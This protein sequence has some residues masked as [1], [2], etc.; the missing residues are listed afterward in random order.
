MPFPRPRE[1]KEEGHQRQ[2]GT[3]GNS[4]EQPSP[5]PGD[6]GRGGLTGV[7]GPI[8]VARRLKKGFQ[9]NPQLGIVLAT[10]RGHGV[11]YVGE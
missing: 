2:A 3:N 9:L 7:S 1:E 5:G 8:Q 10:G 11:V 4:D 6:H